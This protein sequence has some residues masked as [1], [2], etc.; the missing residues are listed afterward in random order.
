M[1]VHLNVWTFNESFGFPPST[2]QFSL[3]VHHVLGSQLHGPLPSPPSSPKDYI[4][5]APVFAQMHMYAHIW[6]LNACTYICIHIDF[7]II[8][9]EC[10]MT[11]QRQHM[12][13]RELSEGTVIWSSRKTKCF[14]W[15]GWHRTAF[16]VTSIILRY[17]TSFPYSVFSH[18]TYS[19][20]GVPT[21]THKGGE[22]WQPQ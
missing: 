9:P 8:V 19:P 18:C 10:G 22:F 3:T 4:V 20:K 15:K 5:S 14:I 7:T 13:E 17:L 16:Y 21:W 6:T 12:F 11:A 2:K 1:C